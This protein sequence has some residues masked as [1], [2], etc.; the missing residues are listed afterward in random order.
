MMTTLFFFWFQMRLVVA[1]KGP[2]S[3]FSGA[4]TK[5]VEMTVDFRSSPLGTCISQDLRWTANTDTTSF[6][7]QLKKVN[8]P[9]ELQR[10]SLSPVPPL[11]CGLEVRP[12]R[13]GADS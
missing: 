2:N 8:L 7:C 9:Q 4:V 10:L 11:L 13:T 12:N 3:W 6:L 5:I 1:L